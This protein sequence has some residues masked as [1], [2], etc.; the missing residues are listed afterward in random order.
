MPKWHI[1]LSKQLGNV[2]FYIIFTFALRTHK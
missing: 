1:L 2:K